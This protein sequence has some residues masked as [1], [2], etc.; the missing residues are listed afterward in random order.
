MQNNKEN[1]ILIQVINGCTCSYNKN[2]A[3][4]LVDLNLIALKSQE[5]IWSCIRS[6]QV[7][8]IYIIYIHLYTIQVVSKHLQSTKQENNNQ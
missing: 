5:T 1:H 6:S 4:T 8:F 7:T 2:N 3:N